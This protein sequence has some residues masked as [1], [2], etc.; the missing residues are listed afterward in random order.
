MIENANYYRELEYLSIIDSLTNIYNHRYFMNHINNEI[1]RINRYKSSLSIIMLDIDNFIEYNEAYGRAEGDILIKNLGKLLKNNAR[2][3]DVVCRYAGD[4]FVVILP[5]TDVSQ[6]KFVALK[7]LN[8]IKKLKAKKTIT[9]SL[10]V[11]GYSEGIKSSDLIALRHYEQ[12][13]VYC[14][15]ALQNLHC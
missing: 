15:L 4:E 3:V 10:G 7:L 11:A 6:A 2:E 12:W 1:K 8:V 14:C 13:F 9:V 5:E